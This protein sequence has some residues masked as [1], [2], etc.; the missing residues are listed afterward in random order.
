MEDK[1][2][3]VKGRENMYV[4]LLKSGKTEVEHL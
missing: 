1:E 3:E 4:Y 2:T